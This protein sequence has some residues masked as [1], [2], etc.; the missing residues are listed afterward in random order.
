VTPLLGTGDPEGTGTEWLKE[1]EN[2]KAWCI[3]KDTRNNGFKLIRK[4][5]T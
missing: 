1:E 2:G 3:G 4:Q 5:K